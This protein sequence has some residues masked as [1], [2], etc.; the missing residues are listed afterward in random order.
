MKN[1]PV[2]QTDY[3]QKVKSLVDGLHSA[4]MLENGSGYCLSMSDIIHKLLHK[5]GIKSKLVECSLMVTLKNPPSLYL[6]GYPGF[7]ANKFDSEKMLQTHIICVTET[8]TPILI[9]LSIS[10]IDK[11]IPF[12]C[13]PIIKREVHTNIAEYDFETSTWTYQEKVD[14]ELPKLHQRSILDRIEQDNKV[15]K[16]INFI[17]TF[18]LVIL[19]I[20]TLNLLRGSYD[21]YQKYINQNNDWG[22]NKSL[23]QPNK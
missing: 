22:P 18:M 10:H 6:M 11:S 20:S 9:D 17:K 12:I 4:G 3:Y 21:F 2:G 1:Y 5:E 14:T 13:A 16:Q 15:T 23:I 7:N 19:G 8:E